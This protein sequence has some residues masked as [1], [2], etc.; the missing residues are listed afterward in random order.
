[1]LDPSIEDLADLVAARVQDALRTRQPAVV[2]DYLTPLEASI[3]LNLPVKT[4]E[5]WRL[6][7]DNLGPAFTRVGRHVRYQVD[8]LRAFMRRDRVAAGGEA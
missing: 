2:P 1:M 4:L 7:P 8:D 5:G 3:F 6:H